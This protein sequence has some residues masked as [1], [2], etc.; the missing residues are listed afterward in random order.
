MVNDQVLRIAV[1][2]DEGEAFSAQAGIDGIDVH[3]D[4]LDPEKD[5]EELLRSCP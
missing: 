2:D 4:F 5:I 3:A 1:V